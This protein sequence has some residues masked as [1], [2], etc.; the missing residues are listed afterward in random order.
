MTNRELYDV[1]FTYTRAQAIEDGVLV[2]VTEQAAQVGFKYPVA[3]TCRLW[4]Y[5]CEGTKAEPEPDVL[6]RVF[7]LLLAAGK[8]A[9]EEGAQTDR[10]H[11]THYIPATGSAL[12]LWSLCGP[13]DTPEPVVTIMLEGED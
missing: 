5:L 11:F 1:V 4:G 6:P 10:V 2:D 3:L 12:K 13:G 7:A 8:A 9:R